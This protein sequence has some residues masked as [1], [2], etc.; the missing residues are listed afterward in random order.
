MG[1]EL[2]DVE[3][4][5]PLL[6]HRPLALLSD[7]DGTLAPIVPHPEDAAVTARARE[8]LRALIGR[9]VKVALVTGRPLDVARRMVGI[10]EAYYAANHGLDMWIEGREETP[11]AVRP[12]VAWARELLRE[13][14]TVDWPGVVV[15][16][17]G[18]IVAYHY[19]RSE[20]EAGALAAIKAAVG[21]SEAARHFR[22]QEGRKVYELRP[23]LEIN[24]GTAARLLVG[25]M[26]ARAVLAMGDDI[27]DVHM[28]EVVRALPVPSV[29]VGVWNEESP[30]VAAGTEYFVRGVEG[31]E[32]LLGEMV[33]SEW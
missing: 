8:A 2:R 27:T 10:E 16:D 9:G 6:E 28:F 24:K 15:E 14:G 30:E 12:Y 17:K 7:I 26:G 3:P 32:W 22:V 4:L 13:V 18:A 20:D 5:R 23:P 31:V 1:E 33:K 11:E 19:R 21:R 25:R 29:V